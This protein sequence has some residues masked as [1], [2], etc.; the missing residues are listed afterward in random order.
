MATPHVLAGTLAGPGW[1]EVGKGAL[2]FVL[3]SLI[4]VKRQ[5][6]RI[7]TVRALAVTLEVQG[8][9]APERLVETLG[10]LDGLIEVTTTTNIAGQD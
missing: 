6:R 8:Q 2:A 4:G 3:S 1:K 7:H 10:T 5:W 9:P